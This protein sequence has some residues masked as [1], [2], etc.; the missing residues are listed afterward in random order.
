MK[1]VGTSAEDLA[2]P[3]V[4]SRR[5]AVELHELVLLHL[6]GTRRPD[7]EHE[8]R[9]ETLQEGPWSANII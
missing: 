2:V 8:V 5:L 6:W 9:W 7:A 3:C 4:N 1:V